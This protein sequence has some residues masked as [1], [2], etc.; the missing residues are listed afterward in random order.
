MTSATLTVDLVPRDERQRKQS[1]VEAAMRERLR[2]LPGLRVSVGGGNSGEALE[3][4]LASDDPDALASAA[5]S[6]ELASA[7]P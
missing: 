3:L 5:A 7:H 1:Q 4:T 2:T 6:V